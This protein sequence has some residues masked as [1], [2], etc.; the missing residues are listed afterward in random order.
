MTQNNPQDGECS[1]PI[2]GGDGSRGYFGIQ[3][4]FG[5]FDERKTQQ[6]TNIKRI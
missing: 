5:V 2:D 1:D 6:K 4:S 3:H